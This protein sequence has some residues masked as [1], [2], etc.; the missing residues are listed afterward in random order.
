M[1]RLTSFTL[2][3]FVSR[4]KLANELQGGVRLRSKWNSEMRIILSRKCVLDIYF[5]TV[6][7]EGQQTE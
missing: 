4:R 7:D 3:H 2:I 5:I 1:K 6:A